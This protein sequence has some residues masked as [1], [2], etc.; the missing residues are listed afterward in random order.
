MLTL[1]Q[2]LST[3]VIF[4]YSHNLHTY[5]HTHT[6]TQTHTHTHS[7]TNTH[8]QIYIYILYIYTYTYDKIMLSTLSGRVLDAMKEAVITT[9]CFLG[10]AKLLDSYM[11]ETSDGYKL[12]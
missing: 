12:L 5:T 6:H 4:T 10:L 8:T 11:I 3:P 2:T 9:Q 1:F 7:H